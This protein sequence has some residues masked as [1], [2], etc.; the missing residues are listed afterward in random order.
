[1]VDPKDPLG[2]FE[3]R[4]GG[5]LYAFDSA[6]GEKL[7]EYALESPPVFNGAAAA[8]RRLYIVQEDGAVACFGE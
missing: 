2:A 3:G 4:K 8:N 5:L 7:A 6:S 1:V